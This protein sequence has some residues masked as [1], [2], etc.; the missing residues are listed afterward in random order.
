M[1]FDGRQGR[2]WR[3]YNFLVEAE[4]LGDGDGEGV[5]ERGGEGRLGDEGWGVKV[6]PV[7]HDRWGWFERSDV[8][9]LEEGREI[10]KVQKR[11]VVESFEV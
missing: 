4:V 3:K 2:R 9:G 5:G 8:E 7:E 1:E 6:D 11:C 10:L